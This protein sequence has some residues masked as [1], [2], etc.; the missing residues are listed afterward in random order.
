M[1]HGYAV[2]IWILYRPQGSQVWGGDQGNCSWGY[3]AAKSSNR[4]LCKT[5]EYHLNIETLQL[6]LWIML[7]YHLFYGNVCKGQQINL[8]C[9]LQG[10]PTF[11]KKVWRKYFCFCFLTSLTTQKAE[12]TLII[13]CFIL[14]RIGSWLHAS[15][16][17]ICN[18]FRLTFF[19]FLYIFF[20]KAIHKS[21]EEI[22][23]TAVEGALTGC[24]AKQRSTTWTL[25][26]C[27]S[28]CG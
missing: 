5:E 12:N 19:F 25:K 7:S 24:Y 10:V 27:S 22:K 28:V 20:L 3:H 8:R 6:C 11:K 2:L 16:D 26:G 13:L 17:F 1:D 21:E 4:M 15:R 14:Y 18:R 23:A 9:T